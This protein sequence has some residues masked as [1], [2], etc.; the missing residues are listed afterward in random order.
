MSKILVVGSINLDRRLAVPKLPQAGETILATDLADQRGGKGANQAVALARLGA[1]VTFLGAI[2]TDNAGAFLKE[3]LVAEG[4]DT[5]NLLTKDEPSGQAFIQVS[6]TGENVISVYPGSN[7]LLTS[8]DI[9]QHASLFEE[10]DYCILQLEIPLEVVRDTLEYCQRY[11]VKVVLNP[12]PY[13]PDLTLADLKKVDY[14][15]PNE[16]E[17]ALFTGEEARELSDFISGAEALKRVT[18]VIVTLGSRGSYWLNEEAQHYQP[19]DKKEA[20][21]TTAAGDSYIGAFVYGLSVGKEVPEAMAFATV[22]SG[23]TVTRPGAQESL[24]F[25]TEVEAFL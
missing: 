11:D 23:I 6:E 17:F 14:F 4:L 7:M 16:T 24:P 9:K 12:A 10:S 2:G 20:I 15:I 1:E 22:V 19:A 3:G 18:N 21:D 8:E 25:L 5:N 13:H